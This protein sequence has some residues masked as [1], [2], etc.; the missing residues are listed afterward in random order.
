MKRF[1]LVGFLILCLHIPTYAAEWDI[2]LNPNDVVAF[3]CKEDILWWAG[4]FGIVSYDTRD[5]TYRVFT[6]KDFGVAEQLTTLAVSPEGHIWAGTLNGDIVHFDGVGWSVNT[7][8]NRGDRYVSNRVKAILFTGD[9]S[10][11]FGTEHGIA[12]YDGESWSQTPSPAG[13][14]LTKVSSGAVDSEGAVW[15]GT[16]DGLYRS[17]EGEWERYGKDNSVLQSDEISAL[18]SGPDGVLWI[19]TMKGYCS[20]DGSNW[21]SYPPLTE[22]IGGGQVITISA[23]TQGSLWIGTPEGLY[24]V[25]GDDRILYTTGNSSLPDNRIVSVLTDNAGDVWVASGSPY[26]EY[27]PKPGLA[28]FDGGA[29]DTVVISGPGGNVINAT[30]VDSSG[31]I[32]VATQNDY[33]MS[34]YSSGFWSVYN[35]NDTSLS[36]INT[37]SADY[38]GR[39]WF[40]GEGGLA[41]YNNGSFTQYTASDGLS[42]TR[43]TVN[44]DGIV[45]FTTNEGLYTF[46]GSQWESRNELIDSAGMQY[47]TC[48]MADSQGSTWFGGHD[49]EMLCLKSDGS[50]RYYSE[51]DG[52]SGLVVRV[53]TE[54]HDGTIWAGTGV[55][56]T[57][58]GLYS[59][60]GSTWIQHET[61]M[62][63]TP[64][65]D[66]AVDGE[67][68][69][70]IVRET[71]N[72]L[73]SYD[74]VSWKEYTP[75]WTL[76]GG[77]NSITIDRDGVFW[78][79]SD[80]IGLVRVDDL[81][82][83]STSVENVES[84]PKPLTPIST[85]PN[86]FNP[87]TTIS[88]SLPESGHA[89][90][91]VYNLSGQ[92]I[93]T[94]IDEPM[95]LGNHTIV[96]D[97]TDDTG[98]SVAAGIYLFRLTA[99]G[100]AA[101]GKMVLVK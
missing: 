85:F 89:S 7:L 5:D 2:M 8:M 70:W 92:K 55:L 51:G 67:N 84:E 24:K 90:L 46:D 48:I 78:L 101:M 98:R 45:W 96:W 22:D 100:T 37:V 86:P 57:G 64:V 23:D 58:A 36:A 94:L 25:A 75:P 76:G 69:L 81:G 32:W 11:L 82:G 17:I 54:D 62:I 33:T 3:D 21:I 12:I 30:A 60:N 27:T 47:A 73:I 26:S 87:S 43:L 52:L 35:N 77:Y 80:F 41:V 95:S 66:I 50:T 79:G 34:R 4:S 63:S 9:G 39:T 42:V 99:T 56:S 1:L 71:K 19:G 44:P 61:A 29:W 16:D 31:D 59:L 97:G 15:L 93:R 74:G 40:G 38:D 20:F 28:R 65:T 18:F 88:F 91:T 6:P 13:D 83:V 49:K 10:L 14:Y 53:V 68:T 72:S